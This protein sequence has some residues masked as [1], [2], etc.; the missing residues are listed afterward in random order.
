MRLPRRRRRRRL[1]ALLGRPG[2][3]VAHLYA[4][5]AGA[6][7]AGRLGGAAWCGEA[8]AVAQPLLSRRLSSLNR[9]P[10]NLRRPLNRSPPTPQTSPLSGCGICL[11]VSSA[12]ASAVVQVTDTCASCSASQLAVDADTFRRLSADSSAGLIPVSYSIVECTPPGNATVSV[13]IYRAGDGGYLRLAVFNLAGSSGIAE[14]ELR[15]TPL[16]GGRLDIVASSWRRM[17]NAHGAQWELSGFPT[18]PLDLRVT[19]GAGR[20]L[21]LR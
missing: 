2:C 9:H 16:V 8:P 3:P 21:L 6:T 10:L 18:P 5:P 20:Q 4:G 19:D 1:H 13:D 12:A 15:Q 14:L 11:Q 7:Q 17:L